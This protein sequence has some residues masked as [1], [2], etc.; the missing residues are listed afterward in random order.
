[1]DDALRASKQRLQFFQ[2]VHVFLAVTGRAEDEF[3]FTYNP[4]LSAVLSDEG[5]ACFPHLFWLFV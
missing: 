3:K 4:Y 2:F 5:I 1:M